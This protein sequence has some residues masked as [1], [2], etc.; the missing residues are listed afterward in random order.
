ML[1]RARTILN[2]LH[3]KA[4]FFRNVSYNALNFI[5]IAIYNIWFLLKLTNIEAATGAVLKN[6]AN[7]TSKICVGVP[8]L[9]NLKAFTPSALV[10]RD[11][12]T[13]AFL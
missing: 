4:K 1:K 3:Q 2:L 12:K 8:F 5:L 11:S 7:F 6:F 10:E 13:F 9:I